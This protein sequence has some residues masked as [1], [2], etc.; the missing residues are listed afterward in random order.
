MKRPAIL[1]VLLGLA[2]GPGYYAWTSF[3]S[4]GKVAEHRLGEKGARWTLPNGDVMRFSKGNAFEPVELALDPAMNPV[5]L[6]LV[7]EV[8]GDVRMEPVR[9]NEYHALLLADAL[10]VV[11]KQVTI[12]RGTEQGPNQHRSELVAT[13]DVPAAGKYDF[14]VDDEA[15]RAGFFVQRGSRGPVAVSGLVFVGK[16]TKRVALAAGKWT[17]FSKTGGA[18]VRFTVVA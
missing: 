10:P 7:F 11:E 15:A 14:V 16:R 2:L 3:F 6:V 4:G 17:F 12:R 1:L 18:P 5:G 8:V 9:G 13:L